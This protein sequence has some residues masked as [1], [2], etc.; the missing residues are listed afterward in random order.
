M[1]ARVI[2]NNSACACDL[3][4]AAG[5]FLDNL[6]CKE[7]RLC[8]I[9]HAQSRYKNFRCRHVIC[10]HAVTQDQRIVTEDTTSAVISPPDIHLNSFIAGKKTGTV[11]EVPLDAG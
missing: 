11:V 1:T 2:R 8:D 10:L 4:E 6:I 5:A 7:F 9:L 3:H